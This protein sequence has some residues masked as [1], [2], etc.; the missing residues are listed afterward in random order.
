MQIFAV[1]V[2]KIKAFIYYIDNLNITFSFI[3]LSETWASEC[4]QDLLGITDY[5][6]KQCIPF[7]K[8]KGGGTSLYIHNSFQYRRRGD[9]E[10]PQKLYESVF[11]EVD[12]TI[13]NLN[14]NIIIGEI[15]NPPSSKLKCFNYNLEKLLNAI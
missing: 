14:R 2:K 3:R 6:H 9:L 4:N 5:S 15:Y 13:F 11:I 12:K 1:Q 8:K 7:N 10:L